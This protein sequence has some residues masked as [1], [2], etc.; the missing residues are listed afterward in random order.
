MKKIL[1]EE[2]IL[3]IIEINAYRDLENETF[4]FGSI[5]LKND[6]EYK[7]GSEEVYYEMELQYLEEALLA[8]KENKFIV[9]RS[10]NIRLNRYERKKITQKRLK[11]IHSYTWWTTSYDENL[12]I[13]KRHYISGCKKYAKYCS[14]RKVRNSFDFPLKGNGYRKCFDYWWTIF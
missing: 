14:R 11:K 5:E 12:D 10:K 7:M 13:Y 3:D 4:I 6:G 1:P 8:L 2:L 9:N